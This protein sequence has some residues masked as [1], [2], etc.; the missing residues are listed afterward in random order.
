MNLSGL[1]KGS[2]RDP[3]P[4]TQYTWL[5]ISCPECGGRL[6]EMDKCCGAPEG[7]IECSG[8]MFSVLPSSF[9]RGE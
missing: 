7:L 3:I 1:K 4:G 6:Y 8:C 5:S 9:K 2:K